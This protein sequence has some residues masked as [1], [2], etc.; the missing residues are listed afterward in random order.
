MSYATMGGLG[1]VAEPPA[2]CNPPMVIGPGPDGTPQ[3][4][5]PADGRPTRPELGEPAGHC[6]PR[7]CADF[8]MSNS[9]PCSDGN[10]SHPDKWYYRPTQSCRR[11]PGSYP[12]LAPD[13]SAAQREYHAHL[14]AI[15]EH[16]LSLR[17]DT[18]TLSAGVKVGG[19]LVV[20]GL[21]AA[22]LLGTG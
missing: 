15:H 3:C 13:A 2:P 6:G 12:K 1:T 22:A 8:D 14:V 10:G 19:A 4:L 21:L 5:C 7:T 20:G 9:A 17:C 11:A 16:Y 18:G